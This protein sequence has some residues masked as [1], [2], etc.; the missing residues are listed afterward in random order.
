MEKETTFI[1]TFSYRSK[2]TNNSKNQVL[3]INQVLCGIQ[4]H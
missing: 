1:E 3:N 4:P 2:P